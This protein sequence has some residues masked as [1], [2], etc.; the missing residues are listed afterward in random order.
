MGTKDSS[1]P[2]RDSNAIGTTS[3]PVVLAR[4]ATLEKPRYGFAFWAI[5]AGL[6]LTAMVSALDGSIVS[7]ALPTIVRDLQAGNNY[8]WIINVY[9]LTRCPYL[10]AYF[11]KE[12]LADAKNACS[13]AFQPLY[14]QLADL[15]G[16]RW[17][18][19]SSVAIFTFGSGICG[20]ASSADMLIGGRAVQGIG[21]GGINM[22]VDMILCDLVPLR[23]RGKFVGL[24]FAIIATSS[25]FGPLIGGAL[26]QHVSWRWVFYLNLPVG[27]FAMALLFVYLRV[28]HRRELS[29]VQR[30]KRIDWIGNATLIVSTF[31]VLFALT[32]GG[33][34]Y[35]WSS[36]RIISS[37]VLGLMG[38]VL[39]Y[40]F[41]TSSFCREPVVPPILFGN[42]TSS[43]AFFLSFQHS[44]L[45]IWVTYFMPVYFQ[46]VLGSSPTRSGVQ[47]LPL[48]L[49]FPPSAAIGGGLLQKMGRYR[50]IH[51]VGF[52]L[53]TLGFGLNASLGRNTHAGAWVV[54]QITIAIGLGVLISS[55]LPAVQ[56]NLHETHT[57]SSTAAWAF[58]RSI[59]TIWG[60]SIPAAVFDNRFDQ[61]LPR[62]HDPVVRNLLSG[63]RAYE[64]ASKDF[65]DSFGAVVK[66][67][68]I[69]IYSDSLKRV[70]QIAVLFAGVSFLMVWVERETRLRTELQTDFG[71][72]KEKDRDP[73]ARVNCPGG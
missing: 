69:G 27:G 42:R 22:L 59:G 60:V 37:L 52:A 65:I 44:L 29:F 20:G 24:I 49:V 11:R 62:I 3:A 16:R 66:E 54:F 13:A 73:L 36:P 41:E 61:L 53:T 56:A 55:L 67:Q 47:L 40:L 6:A 38:L 1:I 10:N 50:Q 70:W 5:F 58:I 28:A 35:P 51:L 57:A 26:A 68:I 45:S 32:Y 72:E 17:L 23:E 8:V 46:S 43:T 2:L 12:V 31:S 71:L 21:A 15:W 63:G 34:S 9:F 30:V 25:A 14:G 48:V 18:M 19:I 7:T 39:F 4:E 33:T 64:H